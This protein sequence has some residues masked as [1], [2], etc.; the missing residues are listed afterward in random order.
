M[1][2][3]ISGRPIFEARAQVGVDDVRSCDLTTTEFRHFEKDRRQSV[4]ASRLAVPVHGVWASA[5]QT[6]V[7]EG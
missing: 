3:L 7:V 4:S 5:Q 6:Q 1:R 2:S